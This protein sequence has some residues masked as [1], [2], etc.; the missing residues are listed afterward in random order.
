M[1]VYY[2][3]YQNKSKNEKTSGKYYGRPKYTTTVT[4]RDLAKEIE[5]R[6]TVHLADVLAVIASLVEVMQEHLQSSERVT[7]TGL[8][9]FKVGITTKGAAT[10]DEFTVANI[11]SSRIL[12][13][14]SK[15]VNSDHTVATRAMSTGTSFVEWG[16]EAKTKKTST[17]DSGSSSDSGSGGSSSDSGS[18]GGSSDSG[19]ADL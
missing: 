13:A 4:E 17:T 19:G 7:L 5:K 8:G 12:F 14:E 3:K 2:K 16:S 6:S 10:A 11:K 1:P 18:G 9:T 15:T